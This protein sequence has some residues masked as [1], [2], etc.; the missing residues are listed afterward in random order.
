MFF[1]EKGL[2]LL[3]AVNILS[4]AIADAPLKALN[5]RLTQSFA[6]KKYI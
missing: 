4:F 5:F 1:D 3:P 2:T 6:L